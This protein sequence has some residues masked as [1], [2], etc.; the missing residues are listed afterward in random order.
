[1]NFTKEQRK[2]KALTAVTQKVKIGLRLPILF[3]T[4]SREQ[5]SRPAEKFLALPETITFTVV[6]KRQTL[7][8]TVSLTNPLYNLTTL[9]SSYTIEYYP[10]FMPHSSKGTLTLGFQIMILYEFLA[11]QNVFIIM[12]YAIMELP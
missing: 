4:N 10:T 9:F 7:D 3:E 11:T 1:M 12:L 2:A 5:N 6:L 8:P